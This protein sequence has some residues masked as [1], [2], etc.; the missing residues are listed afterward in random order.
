MQNS[1]VLG[2]CRQKADTDQ[3]RQEIETETA[4]AFRAFRGRTPE[5]YLCRG[6][7]YKTQTVG[8]SPR[9]VAMPA[10]RAATAQ[11]AAH[12]LPPVNWVY[13]RSPNRGSIV[14]TEDTS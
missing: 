10:L 14:F 6:I 3:N 1:R 11:I 5:S 13:D 7:S 12:Y 4:H 8:G 2:M 9:F